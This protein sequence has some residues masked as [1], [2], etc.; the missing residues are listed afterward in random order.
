MLKLTQSTRYRFST[1]LWAALIVL[2]VL[3]VSKPAL[4]EVSPQ[5]MTAIMQTREMAIQAINSHDFSKIKPYLHP[6]LTI[7]TVDNRVFH[8]ADEFEKYWNQQFSGPIKNI[9]MELKGETARTFLSLETE[10][11]YGDANATFYFTDENTATMAMRWTAVLQ[12]FQGKWT[13]QSLH[14][15]ANLLDN[16]LLS[17]TQGMVRN[18]AIA[19]GIG[20]IL[21]GGAL[22]LFLRRNQPSRSP[23]SIS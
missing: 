10:V 8:S 16:P 4:A 7:T 2:T 17:A 12:K 22:V 21:L 20:G 23:K 1:V 15:S 14:F 3:N 18:V 9:A 6:T 13:I 19:T 5:E 11:A